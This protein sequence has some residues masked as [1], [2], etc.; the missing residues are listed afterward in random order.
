M[1]DEITRVGFVGLGR[2]GVGIARN[3][4]KAGFPLTVCNRTPEKTL[5]L[6]Q[7][8]ASVA[9]SPKQAAEGADVVV[10]CLMDDRS[11][12]DVMGGDEGLLAGMMPGACHIGTATIS[13]DCAAKIAAM[14]HAH[15][16]RYVAGPV[17]GR[18]DAA[19]AGQLLT[20]LAGDQDAIARC[21]PLFKAY[22]KRHV[23]LGSDHRVANSVKLTIN[24]MLL[25][26]IETM[27]EAFAF[28][29]RSGIGGE[30]VAELIE[31][32]TGHPALKE[33]SRRIRARDF[34]RA[35]FEVRSGYKDLDLVMQASADVRVPMPFA[36]VL[37]D[38]FLSAMGH[39]LED[40]D[41]TAISEA[42]RISAG[43]S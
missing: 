42:V 41:W 12:F 13:P 25:A 17:S 4:L 30:L 10:T 26:Q 24:F 9:A 22:A 15:G 28:G 38:R 19:A 16:S 27:S 14:H 37:R 5:T 35:A 21:E 36:S 39:G 31:T 20:H 2:M 40:K 43:L 18:P 32:V 7:Q 6:V 23:N 29:E 8:G 1:G 34:D 11:M 3:I 33:Y